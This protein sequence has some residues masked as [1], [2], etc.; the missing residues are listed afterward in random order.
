M[1]SDAQNLTANRPTTPLARRLASRHPAAGQLFGLD[2]LYD[3]DKLQSLVDQ[4]GGLDVLNDDELNGLAASCRHRW[5]HVDRQ[6]RAAESLVLLHG[7]LGDNANVD[8]IFWSKLAEELARQVDDET[9]DRAT[10]VAA[11]WAK[12]VEAE[13]GSLSAGEPRGDEQ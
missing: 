4:A 7:E 1:N 3:L 2:E 12:H 9:W 6:D 8:V 5:N 10:N 11:S 13:T